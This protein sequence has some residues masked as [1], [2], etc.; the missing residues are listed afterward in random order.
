[1]AIVFSTST[2]TNS[3]EGFS[4]ILNVWLCRYPGLR[5]SVRGFATRS[6][7]AGKRVH[8]APTKVPRMQ[9]ETIARRDRRR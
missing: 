1:M 7:V 6:G 2:R 4:Y 3:G 5:A 8:N 9:R